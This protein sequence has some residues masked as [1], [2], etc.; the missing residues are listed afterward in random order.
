MLLL[1]LTGL[2]VLVSQPDRAMG[3]KCQSSL[4]NTSYTTDQC[5]RVHH[6]A[7]GSSEDEHV[8]YKD[9]LC[10]I[11]ALRQDGIMKCTKIFPFVKILKLKFIDNSI[12]NVKK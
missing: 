9:Q 11:H 4:V 3:I 12:Q 7:P 6:H 2:Y 8:F 5:Y 10:L 1:L